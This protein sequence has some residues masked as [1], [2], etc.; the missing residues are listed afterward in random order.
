MKGKRKRGRYVR[1]EETGRPLAMWGCSL[2]KNVLNGMDGPSQWPSREKVEEWR[3]GR[4]GKE[5]QV[6][7]TLV[8]EHYIIDNPFFFLSPALFFLSS[9]PLHGLFLPG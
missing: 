9:L 7:F 4:R 5:K 1:K 6:R 8:L 2:R 3:G